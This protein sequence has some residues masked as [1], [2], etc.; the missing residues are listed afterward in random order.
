MQAFG[1]WPVTLQTFRIA[2]NAVA[3]WTL[4]IR[5]PFSLNT[6]YRMGDALQ[7]G[8]RGAVDGVLLVGARM[9]E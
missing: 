2:S 7:L 5:L 4:P 3:A 1:S 6:S 9:V 8:I